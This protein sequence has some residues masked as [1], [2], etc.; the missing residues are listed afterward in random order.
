MKA[1]EL[2]MSISVLAYAIATLYILQQ[3][4][5]RACLCYS[6]FRTYN[7]MIPSSYA[8]HLPPLLVKL[9]MAGTPVMND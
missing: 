9:K 5:M 2:L 1:A 7:L 6:L 4:K 3:G 8:F